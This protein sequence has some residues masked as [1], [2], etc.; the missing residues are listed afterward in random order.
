[1]DFVSDKEAE[2]YGS[3]VR[4]PQIKPP[5][6][7]CY[8]IV[9][10]DTWR[11]WR[12]TKN[13]DDSPSDWNTCHFEMSLVK[14]PSLLSVYKEE[15]QC[16][17][18]VFALYFRILPGY[19]PWGRDQ[20][21]S[22]VEDYLF[23]QIVFKTQVDK[24]SNLILLDL[25][26]SKCWTRHPGVPFNLTYSKG[27]WVSVVKWYVW[28]SENPYIMYTQVFYLIFKRN[29]IISYLMDGTS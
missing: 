15:R 6:L 16:L 13:V 5:D 2:I 11:D 1:M 20:N 19:V 4:K 25:L 3:K 22:L 29:Y 14:K 17:G 12:N 28:W 26:L 24:H 7:T 21:L 8:I 27:L 9:E 18:N 10:G 23:P